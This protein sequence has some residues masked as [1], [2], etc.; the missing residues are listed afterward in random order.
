MDAAVGAS[1][2][3][4]G[5]PGTG[6]TAT[7]VERVATLLDGTLLP[8][9]MLVLTPSR[10][11]A[12]LLR[13][14][15]GV[16]V[17]Q[18]TPGPLARSLGSF[19][20]QIVRGAMVH[21]GQE[22][23]ALLTGA[24]QDRIIAELL[25]GDAEDGTIR[26]PDAV[27]QGVRASKGFR[28]ELRTFLAECTELGVQPGELAGLGRD[29]WHAAAEFIDEYRQVMGRL[30]LPHR[31][32]PELLA[33]ATT[34]LLEADAAVLGPLAGLRAVL[35]D[36]AQEL[37]RGGVA[38]VRALRARRIAVLAFGDPDISSGAF[39]GASPQLFAELAGVLETV[40]VLDRPHRQR[41]ALAALTRTV[42]Q[43]IGVA[44][45]VEHRRPPAAGEPVSAAEPDDGP[46]DA[47]RAAARGEVRTIVASSPHEEIDRI[48]AALRGWHLTDGIP[49][50]EMAVIAHDTRQITML[51]A[52]LAGREVPTRAAGVQRP[53]G[54]ESVVR[55]IVG[56]VRLA[57]QPVGEREPESLAEA[58]VSPFGGLDAVGLRRLRAR[59]RH[60]EL[61]AGGSTPA[62]E[63][64]RQA[65]AQPLLFEFVD[66][67]EARIA[68]R[69]AET[70]A[71]VAEAEAAGETIHE[72]LWR[73]WDR[74]RT[75]SG[76]PL[77]AVW[78]EQS[79]Q[80]GGAEVA[81][82]LDSLVALF[83]AAKRFVERAPQEK[84][85]LFVR[86]ILDSEVP[87]DTLS[88]PDR[89][90]LVTLLTPATALGTEFAAVVVAGVQDGVWPNVRLR[91][92]ILETWRLADAVLAARTGT[93][94][95]FP[96]VLDRRRGAMHDELRLFVRALSRAR[97]RLVVTAVDDDDLTPSPFFSFLPEPFTSPDEEDR[98]AHPLTLRGLVARHRRTLTTS[99]DP[100]ARAAAAGQLRLLAEA[101]V[102]GASPEQ[103]YGVTPPSTDRPLRDLSTADVRVSPSR[104]EA[105][106]E[107]GLN[108]VISAL[109][110]DT[111]VPPSA[112]IGTIVHEVMEKVTD[113]DLEKMRRI[114]D[115]HWPELDF[116]TAWIARKERRRADLYIERLR[117]YLQEV[118][119]DGGRVI[120]AETGFR[121]A[122][123]LAGDGEVPAVQLLD[124][125]DGRVDGGPDAAADAGG[126]STA[127]APDSARTPAAGRAL[128]S[129]VIDRIEVYPAGAGE[130]EPA[131]GQ[132]WTRMGDGAA[133]RRVVVVDLKTGKYE[134]DT[135]AN[136]L[137]HAQLAAYQIAV[138]QGL[139]EGADPA[140]LVGARLVIVSKTVGKASYRVAHQHTLDDDSRAAFLR[141]VAEAGRGMAASSFTAQVEAH[142]ADTQ[143]R[144]QTCRIHTIPAVS[145]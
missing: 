9:E 53:L 122:V 91:G 143:V 93:P 94:A 119:R 34:I 121:F 88:T 125:G 41:P 134:P 87:E 10:Q 123:E 39:R 58:L 98:L 44:G 24:D 1:G 11:A 120:G 101:G 68:R 3:V 85:S 136:V 79:A 128:V 65:M 7:L 22:P 113:G 46:R 126:V 102:P 14:R 109:G 51:E 81:R 38:L 72:L 76:A 54:S 33:E 141:R 62:R 19:A 111:V 99:H 105:F 66:A 50:Q 130:H 70:L 82:S 100:A 20:F 17:G 132:K 84:P 138:Q 8:D 15:I 45:R 61:G 5:A 32:V 118:E 108:W 16:R 12:T 78:R 75:V 116:E 89:P 83:D 4:I 67:P 49:W 80:P 74:A 140:A 131:R 18:A 142:C 97:T 40:F 42:T 26:W 71:Q 117:S 92:G 96:G 64:L 30:R 29:V 63:L 145:A 36:D 55:D 27:S 90:G 59:L 104:L 103:W 112:G 106:E 115:E 86:D 23:P 95:V 21:A 37:T 48:A 13:D 144:V 114:V 25:A 2:V 110:G 139:V 60:H 129:G 73:V 135:E 127:D 47:D 77:Q 56:V 43:A 6:K 133:G 31:D 124:T 57:L 28:S 137:E 69:F 107:C 52:E 35:I